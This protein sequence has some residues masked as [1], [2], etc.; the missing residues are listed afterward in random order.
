M[1]NVALRHFLKLSFFWLASVMALLA[2]L[3]PGP[4]SALD[5]AGPLCALRPAALAHLSRGCLQAAPRRFCRCPRRALPCTKGEVSPSPVP[6][7]DA[8]GKRCARCPG[9]LGSAGSPPHCLP[10]RQ[11]LLPRGER[12]GCWGVQD[13]GAGGAGNDSDWTSCCFLTAGRR[14]R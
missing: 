11:L 5:P 1:L 13:V 3:R 12:G 2:P 7:E 9:R 4:N 10:T 14:E 6:S 8:L